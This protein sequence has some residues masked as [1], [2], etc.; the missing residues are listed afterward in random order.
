VCECAGWGG[1]GA[2]ATE[3]HEA[4][5]Y[6]CYDSAMSVA[7]HVYQISEN[8]SIVFNRRG[9]ETQS[10][11]NRRER[12]ERGD[13]LLA[14]TQKR[15]KYLTAESAKNAKYFSNKPLRS[16]RSWRF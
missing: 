3:Q 16:P 4:H 13:V 6:R 14:K 15:E 1:V 5:E 7:A 10:R 8:N 11:Y 2:D 9:A 12:K